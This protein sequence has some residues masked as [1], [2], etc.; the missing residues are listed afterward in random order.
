MK[1]KRFWSITAA[2]FLLMTFWV[3]PGRAED[4]DGSRATLAGLQGVAVIIEDLQ[5]NVQ[6]YAVKFGLS[7]EQIL[8]DVAQRLSAGGIRMVSGSECL[9]MPGQPVLY[10]NINTHE[11][12]KY[13][14]AYD[15]EVALRQMATLD[16]NPQMKT[17]VTTWSLNITG[18]ANIGTLHLIRQD[19]AVM[20]EKFVHAYR[21]VN[22][23]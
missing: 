11:T 18:Q 17:V 12:E 15:V 2:F 13:W 20:V 23:K 1:Q 16:A 6:K 19:T 10:I 7:K 8:K 14:Y 4:S 21:T 22:R 3:V 9:K 5:P